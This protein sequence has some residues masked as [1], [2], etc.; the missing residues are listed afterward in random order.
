MDRRKTILGVCRL[1]GE[2]T[3]LSFE[4]VPPKAAFND[5]PVVNANIK[6]LI[7]KE[8]DLDDV[9]GKMNQRGA[10]GFLPISRSSG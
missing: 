4:H 1:C 9:S 2:Y 6:M 7:K 5:R 8:A 3:K 10:G